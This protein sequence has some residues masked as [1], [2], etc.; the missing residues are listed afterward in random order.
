[1]AVT[2]KML[3]GVAPKI[4]AG[5]P[6]PSKAPKHRQLWKKLGGSAIHLLA[7]GGG[8]SGKT[9]TIMK[10]IVTRCLGAPGSTHAVLRFR[11]NSLKGSII[12]DTLPKVMAKEFPGQEWSLNKSD[13]YVDIPAV[14]HRGET[15]VS[16]IYFGGLDDADRTEK[17]LGQGH[18]TIYLNE[19]SQIS[20]S[21]RN[22]A[23]TRLSQMCELADGSGYLR[24]R[25]YYDENPP[26]QGHW[27]HKLFIKKLEPS[28]GVALANPEDYDSIQVNPIDNP[29]LPEEMMKMYNN[30]PPAEKLRFLNGE[31]GVLIDSALWTYESIAAATL[32]DEYQLPAFQQVVVSV[33]PSGC[34]GPEDERSDEIGIVVVALGIDN[35]V[36]ILE[37][38]SGHFGPGGPDGWGARSVRLYRKWMA[39]CIVGERNFGGAMVQNTIYT[40][41]PNVPFREVTATRGKVVRAEPVSTLY[42]RGLVKHLEP[43]QK[44]EEQMVNFS[45]AGY[46]GDKSPDRVDAMVW[47]VTT[48][49]VSMIAGGGILSWYE[50]QARIQAAAAPTIPKLEVGWALSGSRQITPV[51]EDDGLMVS[52]F[53]PLGGS[54]VIYG[55]Q[56]T[57]YVVE[58]DGHVRV[59]PEDVAPL[60]QSGFTKERF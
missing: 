46:L 58:Q 24:L 27:T 23:V 2:P 19:C 14:N 37:D 10:A 12:F 53:K 4:I 43:M 17:I 16:R 18:S 9:F 5:A 11:F 38:A 13:W 54:S 55:M 32:A 35:V 31:F 59:F 49:A 40:T 50:E 57:R 41:D 20:Y 34:R 29:F 7:Y 22:K 48:V 25:A 56:G 8:R 28:T 6:D 47:G 15:L 52:L 33:D 1:M 42:G 44:L 3:P 36:Y 39:D 30:M 26:K 60:M 51:S 21:A 45:T